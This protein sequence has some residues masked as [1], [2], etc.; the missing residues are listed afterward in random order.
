MRVTLRDLAN[1]QL[2]QSTAHMSLDAYDAAMADTMWTCP[3]CGDE[4]LYWQQDDHR[5]GGCPGACPDCGAPLTLDPDALKG[6]PG[7]EHATLPVRIAACSGCEFVREV[8]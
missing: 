7:A 6:L 8:S 2:G 5:R 4:M 3:D 1:K